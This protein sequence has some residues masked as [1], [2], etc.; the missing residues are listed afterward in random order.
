M[1]EPCG[2]LP[3]SLLKIAPV[4]YNRAIIFGHPKLWCC[5]DSRIFTE[6]TVSIL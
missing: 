4:S 6:W 1:E 2:Q 5:G 3:G